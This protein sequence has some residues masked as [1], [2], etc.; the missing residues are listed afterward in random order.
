M[1]TTCCT[2]TA[3]PDPY[4]VAD[5]NYTKLNRASVDVQASAR[6]SLVTADGDKVTL[7]TSSSLQASL[8]TYDYLGR[9]QGQTVAARGEEFQ[10]STSS[11]YALT[12]EGTL[13]EEELADIGQLLNTLSAVSE[14]FVAGKRQDGLQ[15]L[16]QLEDLD[17]IVS[18][19][20]SFSYT[21]RVTAVAASQ[22]SRMAAAQ[23]EGNPDANLAAAT[24]GVQ[25]ADSFIDL[26]RRVAK[27]LES[28]N[29]FEK[30]PERFAQLFNKLAHQLALDTHDEKLAERIQ[31][32]HLRHG[33]RSHGQTQQL[34]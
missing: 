7:N 25:A 6:I 16:T 22:V 2:N 34:I 23:V 5:F 26:L 29:N 20:A 21:R 33:R 12:V 1:N 9:T 8:Q 30:I 4:P 15:H 19:E 32:E 13:D 14:D 18:F 10:L 17:S 27:Q 31:S 28:D 11:G 3:R 24:A